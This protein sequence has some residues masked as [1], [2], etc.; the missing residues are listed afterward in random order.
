MRILK[1]FKCSEI[2]SA[3]SEGVTGEI[4]GSADSKEFRVLIGWQEVISGLQRSGARRLDDR[5]PRLLLANTG[6]NS[7]DLFIH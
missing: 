5:S 6:E 3:D 7:I 4:F 1:H 2:V